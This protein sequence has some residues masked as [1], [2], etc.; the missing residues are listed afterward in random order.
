MTEIKGNEIPSIK[1]DSAVSGSNKSEHFKRAHR[2]KRSFT[3]P[4]DENGRYC[5]ISRVDCRLLKSWLRGEKRF[6][7]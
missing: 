2:A 7:W 5:V 3:I 1:R 4:I 6:K